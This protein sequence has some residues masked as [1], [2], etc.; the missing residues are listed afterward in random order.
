MDFSA[1][2]PAD[3][4]KPAQKPKAG[5]G[6]GNQKKGEK[7]KKPVKKAA[8]PSGDQRG[9]EY[10]KESNFSKWYSQ[11]ITKAELIEYYDISGCYILRPSSFYIWERITEDADA[12]FKKHGV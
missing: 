3:A 8:G 10:T 9:I 2:A 6:E 11:V 1:D 7:G 12:E 5:Y 4:G